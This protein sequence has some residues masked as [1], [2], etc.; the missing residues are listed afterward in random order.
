MDTEA[1]NIA[2]VKKGGGRAFHSSL[3]L[4]VDFIREQRQGRKTWKEIAV[5][6]RTEKACVISFQGVHQFY[7]R[8]L[9]RSAHPHWERGPASAPVAP[10]TVDSPRK[11][12]QASTPSQRSFRKPPPDSIQLNDPNDV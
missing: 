3:E 8:Y 1:K 11:A 2:R 12:P 9:I 5:L 6:L 7:R 10:P 4:F